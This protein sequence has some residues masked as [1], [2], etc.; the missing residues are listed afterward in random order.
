MKLKNN[1]FKNVVLLEDLLKI[2]YF[3]DDSIMQASFNKNLHFITDIIDYFLYILS[4]QKK[5][6]TKLY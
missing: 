5:F 6:N 3:V 2:I 4:I 1:L